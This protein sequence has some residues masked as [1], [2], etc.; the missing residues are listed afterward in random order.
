[1]GKG[2]GGKMSNWDE[3][4]WEGVGACNEGNVKKEEDGD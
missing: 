3:D 2:M 1:M 4:E